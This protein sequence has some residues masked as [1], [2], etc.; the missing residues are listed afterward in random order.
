MKS[1]VNVFIILIL[2]LAVTGSIF[3][4]GCSENNNNNKNV[5][6]ED[7]K[8]KFDNSGLLSANIGLVNKTEENDSVTYGEFGSGVIFEKKDGEYYA[9]TAAHVVSNE[10]A[11][12]LVYTV[13]TEMKT[14][15]I[16]GMDDLN[17]LSVEVYEKMY[18]AEVL[19]SG[20]DNDIAVI[21]FK[22]DED[23]SVM[24][25]AAADPEIDDRIICVGNPENEW[26]SV[27]YGKVLSGIER[28][29]E[30]TSHPSSCMKHSAYIKLGSSGG[31][32]IAENMEL[33]GI[34]PGASLTLNDNSF[35]YGVLIPVSEINKFL[36]EW[37]NNK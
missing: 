1:K 18:K 21:C 7:M 25:L 27:S 32:A 29:G 12:I 17:T 4:S 24:K 37:K 10:N 34:T 28:F 2:V 36:D 33:V 35:N 23:L 9:L 11:Q 3:L 14:D 20:T 26:F 22:S 5:V 30:F 31:A 6:Y 19:Y 13:N 16:P 8:E 15:N